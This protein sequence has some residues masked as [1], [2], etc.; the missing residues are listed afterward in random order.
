V[1]AT[2]DPNAPLTPGAK[3]CRFCPA[4][5][6]MK[7][8]AIKDKAL[9]HAQE[10]FG[11]VEFRDPG[12]TV[13][14]KAEELSN[15][16]IKNLYELQK[17]VSLYAAEVTSYI[18]SQL[19]AGI[20]FP[21]FKLVKKKGGK[22]IWSDSAKALKII[23]QYKMDL[24]KVYTRP[25]M[26]TPPQMEKAFNKT[27]FS[28]LSSCISKTDPGVTIARIEDKRPAVCRQTLLGEVIAE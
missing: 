16:Q 14:P 3:Q 20:D 12:K 15:H 8:P 23:A 28:R 10:V 19:E 13:L 4:N 11:T 22:R 6:Q 1:K 24:D 18:Q 25:V 21:G 26:K 17:C 7:C 2:L 5:K 27:D 9:M